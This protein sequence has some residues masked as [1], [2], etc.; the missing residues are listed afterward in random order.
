LIKPQWASDRLFLNGKL[1]RADRFAWKKIDKY[2]GV[3]AIRFSRLLVPA[4][5]RSLMKTIQRFLA[6]QSGATAIEYGLIAAAIAL[7][8]IVIVNG[9]GGKLNT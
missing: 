4:G 7:A 2:P 8:I 9:L 1:S 5:N 6:D 3:Y